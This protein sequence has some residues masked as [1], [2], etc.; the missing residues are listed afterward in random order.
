MS[1]PGPEETTWRD[2]IWGAVL[3]WMMC[4]GVGWLIAWRLCGC[5][6]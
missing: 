4:R 1:E 5:V 6:P 2:I 3:L